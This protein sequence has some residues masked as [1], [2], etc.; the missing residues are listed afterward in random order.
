[1]SP[2]QVGIILPARNRAYALRRTLDGIRAQTFS[3]WE[4]ILIDDGSTDGTR[5]LIA[6]YQDSRFVYVRNET[7]LGA[8]KARNIGR[9]RTRAEFIA[10]QDAGDDWLPEKLALQVE[11]LRASPPEV[12]M[13]YSSLTLVYLD[14]SRMTEH[15]PTFRPGDADTYRRALGMEVMGIDLP[16]CL[17]RASALEHC[18]GFD[19]ALGRWIDLELFMRL[20]KT[21]RFDHVEGLLTLCYERPDAITMNVDALMA[22]HER[23]LEKYARDLSPENVGAHR[24]IVGRRLLGSPRWSAAGRSML[25]GVLRAPGAT[26]GDWLWFGLS[27]GG[28]G[29]HRLIRHLRNR[30]RRLCPG[31]TG[32]F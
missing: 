27:L 2:P 14:G 6:S 21:C 23:I 5:E 10:F 31:M 19:E 3:D 18:G 11:R 30:L 28:P 1:M 4:L 7:P 12:G 20:A 24:R 16:A 9:A 22:A 26:A 32:G 8:A 17:F 13:V 15:A 29:L 25:Y